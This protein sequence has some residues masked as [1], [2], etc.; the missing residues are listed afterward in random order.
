MGCFLGPEI[1]LAKGAQQ[2]YVIAAF[3]GLAILAG[4]ITSFVNDPVGLGAQSLDPRGT[5]IASGIAATVLLAVA[6]VRRE[7]FPGGGQWLAILALL[8][9]QW[10]QG[11]LAAPGIG[12]M[13]VLHS[14]P[15]GVAFLISLAAPLWLSLLAALQWIPDQ[16]PRVVAGA[17]IAGIGA[18]CLA[19][20]DGAYTVT[21]REIPVAVL[22]VVLGVLTVFSW[23][24]ARPRLGTA[25]TTATAGCFLLLNALWSLATIRLSADTS[26]APLDWHAAGLPLLFSALLSASTWWLWFWLLRRMEL[27]A[28]GMRVLAA[29][30]AA[31]VPGFVFVSL[32][33]WRIDTAFVIAVAA[34]VVAL[35]ARPGDEQLL[36]LGLES[37]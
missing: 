6:A 25:T 1:R 26:P 19:T 18:F 34:L 32:T 2:R 36:A 8:A 21:P 30:A 35:R 27:A 20:P 31:I 24:Y 4:P 7:R 22:Q 14:T 11:L 29:W 17:S 3:I 37:P 28:F 13:S 16:V 10:L 15:W 9:P 23:A 33:S 12:G 5:A